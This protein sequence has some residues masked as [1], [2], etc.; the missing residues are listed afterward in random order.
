VMGAGVLLV[1]GV[2]AGA[3]A[4]SAQPGGDCPPG[5]ISVGL[6]CHE[7]EPVPVPPDTGQRLAVVKACIDAQLAK[8]VGAQT[9]RGFIPSQEDLIK[10]E[11]YCQAPVLVTPVPVPVQP[12]SAE[13]NLNNNP[14][15]VPV[16]G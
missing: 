12:P 14:P 8:L 13:Q 2:I 3:D 6:V 5:P 1:C 11:L 15:P 4:A 16:T 7:T 9:G 10:V